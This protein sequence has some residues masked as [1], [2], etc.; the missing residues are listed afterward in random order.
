MSYKETAEYAY[1]LLE[2]FYSINK[3][4]IEELGSKNFKILVPKE[5][6]NLLITRTGNLPNKFRNMDIESY[7]GSTIEFIL[8]ENSKDGCT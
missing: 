2:H 4:R 1:D 7:S 6:L 8:K 5:I 3:S